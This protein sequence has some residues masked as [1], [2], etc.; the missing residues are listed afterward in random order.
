MKQPKVIAIDKA[1]HGE[2]MAI[3]GKMMAKNPE[4]NVSFSKAIQKLINH[5]NRTVI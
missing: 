3:R 5:Y 4:E 1:V 2:L